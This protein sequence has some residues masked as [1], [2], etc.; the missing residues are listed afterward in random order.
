[1]LPF[2]FLIFAATLLLTLGVYGLLV[3][4][5]IQVQARLFRYTRQAP[6]RSDTPG[7]KKD[8][9]RSLL[10]WGGRIFASSKI[11]DRV[12]EKLAQADIPLRGEEFLFL[13]LILTLSVPFF[14]VFLIQNLRLAVCGGLIAAVFPWFHLKIRRQSRLRLLNTQ[15]ADSLGVM[16]NALRAGYSFLQTM[17]LVATE[18]SP[19]L[20][21]EYKRALREMQ[22]GASTEA[23]LNNMSR[24]VGSDDLDLVITALLIQ[25]Q[26]GGNLAEILESIAGTIRER[27]RIKGE[28]KT[29][30]AQGRIS[31]IIIGLLPLVLL[32]IL[33]MVNPQYVK[34]LFTEP[35][36]LG[37]LVGAVCGEVLGMLIIRR[38]IDIEV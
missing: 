35:V 2:L 15:L 10:R 34:I 16:T 8:L 21:G 7:E 13:D 28:I 30:T 29:L 3:G 9:G 32:A 38:V 5:K 18:T 27:V 4:D 19:P 22:L 26:V 31:G 25:R 24:R 12:E 14:V 33:F 23:A 20:A 36:G 17:E 6:E 37:L 1:M 11:T